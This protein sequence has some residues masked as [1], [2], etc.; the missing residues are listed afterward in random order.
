VLL[1]RVAGRHHLLALVWTD[2][3]YTGGLVDSCLAVLALVLAIVKRSDDQR[4]FVVP[5][6]RRIVECL[7]THLLRTRRLT[8][9]CERRTT[10]AGA[11]V[12]WSMILLGHG[13]L[14]LDTVGLLP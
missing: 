9:D 10:S 12:S 11:M 3:G 1:E 8:R 13:E 14:G 2:G 6:R 5:P 7:F 4:E